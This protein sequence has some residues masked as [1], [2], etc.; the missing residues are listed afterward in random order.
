LSIFGEKRSRGRCGA[1]GRFF[2]EK[3]PQKPFAEAC[4]GSRYG[5]AKSSSFTVPQTHCR[6]LSKSF[7]GASFRASREKMHRVRY[8]YGQKK[9]RFLLPVFVSDWLRS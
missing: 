4:G 5:C 8:E 3:A 2:K 1:K 9:A 7:S 6:E